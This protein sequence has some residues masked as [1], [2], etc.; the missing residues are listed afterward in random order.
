MPASSKI[1]VVSGSDLEPPVFHA[2]DERVEGQR[3][4]GERRAVLAEPLRGGPGHRDPER[5]AAGELLGPR[6]GVDHDALAGAGRADQDRAAL[7]AGDDLERVGLL[8]AEAPADPLG[9]L[10]LALDLACSPTSRPAGS[11]RAPARR[12]IACSRAR[13]ASVVISPPSKRQDAALGDHRVCATASASRGESSPTDCSSSTARSSPGLERRGALGQARFDAILERLLPR[14]GCGKLTRCT[15]S[16]APKPCRSPVCD[17]TRCRSPRVDEHLRPA[18]LE[19]ELAQLAALGGAAVLRAEALGG[20]GDLA[21]A[22]GEGV[23]QPARHPGDLE[24][25]AVFAGALLDRI[26]LRGELVRERR[27]VERADLPRA[28]GRS[29]ARRPRRSARPRGPRR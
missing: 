19:L 15:A 13:T 22:A 3:L 1:T 2:R 5:L 21:V 26:A 8:V 20:P 7:G 24:V 28:S 4:T 16:S 17:Q 6:G 9:D 27:A 29:A 18:V 14:R 10:S 23:E 11:A 25:A 12:S